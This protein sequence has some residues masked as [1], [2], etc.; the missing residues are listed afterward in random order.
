MS[1]IAFLSLT[2][3]INKFIFLKK[4][5]FLYNLVTIKKVCK[6]EKL[7][8]KV[9]KLKFLKKIKKGKKEC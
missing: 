4:E 5:I 3:K 2:S 6:C 7:Y 9:K 1:C 8:V